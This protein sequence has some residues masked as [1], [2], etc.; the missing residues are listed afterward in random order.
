MS[1]RGA[2]DAGGKVLPP[3]M[4]EFLDFDFRKALIFLPEG[5]FQGGVDVKE[6]VEGCRHF[7]FQM[8][9]YPWPEA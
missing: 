9:V 3:K 2:T 7:E 6:L 5:R 1:F 8:L 4:P